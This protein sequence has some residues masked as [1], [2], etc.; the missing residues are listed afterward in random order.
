[1]VD[2]T[3]SD[4]DVLFL[5]KVAVSIQA[6]VIYAI[7]RCSTLEVSMMKAFSKI[8]IAPLPLNRFTSS[9]Q[10]ESHQWVS[11]HHPTIDLNEFKQ[12]YPQPFF[13]SDRNW[14]TDFNTLPKPELREIRSLD[15]KRGMAKFVCL[16]YIIDEVPHHHAT[17]IDLSLV[18]DLQN[19]R[20]LQMIISRNGYFL[21]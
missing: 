15:M 20:P 13:V 9:G 19:Q 12:I 1:M 3:S 2:Q 5:L 7:Q 6:R 16:R 8:A 14:N 21:E 11:D 10:S 4:E 18:Y 17:Y